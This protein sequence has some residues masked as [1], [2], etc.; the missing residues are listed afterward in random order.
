MVYGDTVTQLGYDRETYGGTDAL[1][2]NVQPKVIEW[3]S[4]CTTP[5]L[6]GEGDRLAND[7]FFTAVQKQ[8]WELT[9]AHIK[10][11]EL[12]ALKRMTQRGSDFNPAWVRR[13]MTKVDNLAA[14][15]NVV[16]I[17]GN[18]KTNYVAEQVKEL[19]YA[20]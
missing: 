17:N 9:I 13:T 6:I 3:L 18:L 12:V 4:A 8:G 2:F 16:T 19:L 20:G 5:L 15:W 10:V 7:A 1:A 11:K 14:R